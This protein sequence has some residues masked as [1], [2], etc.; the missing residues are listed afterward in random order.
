MILPPWLPFAILG[1]VIGSFLN[2]VADRLP[3]RRS[4]VRPPSRCPSCRRRLEPLE[5]V[6]ILSYVALRGRCRSCSARIPR[7]VL[8]VELGTAAVF[9]LAAWRYGASP[10]AGISSLFAALLIASLVIDLEHGLIP[11]RLIVP[12]LGVA[13]L[14]APFS[15]WVDP[16]YTLLGGAVSFGVLF[17]IALVASG[18]MGMGDVKLGAFLGLILGFPQIV[19]GLLLAFI[20]GGAIAAALLVSGRLKR[21][22]KIPFGPFM[23]AAGI[24]FLLYGDPIQY[25]WLMRF[26]AW[27]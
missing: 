2:V 13:T 9:G 22:D 25:W 19:P 8:A 12:A 10:R 24:L 27:T 4:L 21:D 23:A 3:A 16:V 1:A 26:P 5:L 11:N 20:S 7:R 14:V 17:A 6:P 15:G 18:G